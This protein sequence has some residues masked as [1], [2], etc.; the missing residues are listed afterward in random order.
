M[1]PSC[2][3]ALSAL[4]LGHAGLSHA[5]GSAGAE[6]FN[7]LSLDANARAVAMGGAYTA[8]ATD[9]NA[10]LYNPAGLG[11]VDQTEATFMHN[12]YLQGVNQEYLGLAARQGWGANLNYLDS[13]SIPETTIASP[14]GTG[15]SNSLTD[16]AVSAGYG[17]AVADS[18]SLGAGA[19]YVQESVAGANGRGYALDVGALYAVP[20]VPR[21]TL[22]LAVRNIGPTVKFQSANE[23]L[24][25]DVRGGAAY[26]FD[27]LGQRSVVSLDLSKERSANAVV[28]GGFETVFVKMMAVRVGFNT[29]N[30][31]GPKV[32]AGLGWTYR[33]FA[34]DYAFVPYGDLGVSNRISVT[35]RW[36]DKKQ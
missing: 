35:V 13:G 1:R 28:Q 21:L 7:F 20:A 31:A 14:S 11:R 33:Q 8:L 6:P 4:L 32:T 2:A 9:A 10:L 29:G 23:N 18:L 17:R 15:A 30:D 12:Q 22:G 25:L 19:K 36:G 24:P 27:L 34:L 5:A 26:A 3:A 16:M